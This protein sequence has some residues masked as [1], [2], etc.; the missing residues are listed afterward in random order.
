MPA[1]PF[2]GRRPGYNGWQATPTRAC[3]SEGGFAVPADIRWVI[4]VTPQGNLRIHRA[5]CPHTDR[6]TER[7]LLE[8]DRQLV[9]EVR[10]AQIRAP[11]VVL[12]ELPG[13]LARSGA[14]SGDPARLSPAGNPG[15]GRGLP[16]L[17]APRLPSGGKP[18]TPRRRAAG[19]PRRS[20]VRK[21]A[22]GGQPRSAA[23]AVGSPATRSVLKSRR[24]SPLPSRQ[25][26]SMTPWTRAPTLIQG[27]RRRA[28]HLRRRQPQQERNLPRRPGASRMR[29]P[30]GEAKKAAS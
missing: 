25:R 10:D 28:V 22:A 23:S 30:R 21:A 3:P 16:V 24:T 2:P 9:G 8:E 27:R 4:V 11:G 6:S 1:I 19:T 14:P 26:A 17:P 13:R 18:R 7:I 15:T 29:R 20:P 12:Q 5:N